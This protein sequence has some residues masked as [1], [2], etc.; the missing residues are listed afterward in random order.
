MQKSVYVLT[1][2]NNS[3][4]DPYVFY[5]GCTNDL[6]EREAAHRRAAFNPDHQ[7]YNT[8]KYQWIRQLA[9]EGYDFTFTVVEENCIADDA[10]EY[11]YV[12]RC[13]EINCFAGHSFYDGLPLTNMKAGDFLNE[14]L[15]RNIRTPSA[16]RT[17]IKNKNQ[18][19]I[20]RVTAYH[21]DL[22]PVDGSRPVN[23]QIVERL[24]NQRA[25]TREMLA[26][27]KDALDLKAS[28]QKR[29]LLKEKRK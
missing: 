24:F 16:I 2:D 19:K 15:Q 4:R 23:G 28:K 7:E 29:K 3:S 18:P 8:Y 25:S 6:K 5:V 26:R 17:F 13:A 14:M 10:D 1:A 20:S 22:G 27:A 9:L 21:R 11:S 12:L